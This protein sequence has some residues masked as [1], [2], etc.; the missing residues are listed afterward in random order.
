MN[1]LID[2][3]ILRV[4]IGE[5]AKHGGVPLSEAIVS[6]A[7]KRGMAGAVVTRGV[8]GFGAN[9]LLHTSKILRLSEDLP[10]IVQIV[11][12][13]ARI[14]DFLPHVDALVEEGTI[15]VEKAQAIF[16]MPMRIRDIMSGDVAT[17]GPNASLSEVSELL[18][19]RQVKALPVV[20]G[21]H[22]KGII[23]GGDLLQRADMALRLDIQSQLPPDLLAG[24][25]RCLDGEGLT[26][27]DVMTSPAHVLNI[28]TNVADA[29]ASM[30]KHKLKRLP[31]VDD[32]GNL[33]GIVSRADTL[34][35]IAK[36]VSVTEF[37]PELPQ[38]LKRVARDVM[39]QD[40]P[41]VSPDT[42]MTE[43]LQTIVTTPFRRVVVV[44]TSKRVVG[45]ILDRD[46][47]DRYI[48]QENPGLLHFLLN[49][50]SSKQR[51][52]AGL[53]GTAKDVMSTEVFTVLPDTPLTD[54][55]RNLVEKKAKRLVVAD[56][57][58]RLLGM[59]DRERIVQALAGS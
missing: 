38:G 48:K 20:E 54:V 4:F 50:L 56:A 43:I 24:H 59:V 29:L 49:I 14:A 58:G 22:V 10:I 52:L 18:I 41:T 40:V 55:T 3:Q 31:V 32:D 44:D 26:A 1:T 36:V 17:I 9:S 37:L 42:P 5:T 45:I 15:V 35:A 13:P 33:M 8:M 19:R 2:V 47:V 57:D 39:F 12:I 27:K 7:I 30:A 53:G 51:D 28:K 46:L 23:T 11:D 6:E 21:N 34:R 25:I 16:H